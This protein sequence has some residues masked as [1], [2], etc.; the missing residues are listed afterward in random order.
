[1]VQTGFGPLNV[2]KFGFCMILEE[3]VLLQRKKRH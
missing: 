1:M 3:M 2:E